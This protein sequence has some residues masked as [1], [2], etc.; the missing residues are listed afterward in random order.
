V[1]ACGEFVIVPRITILVVPRKFRQLN[2]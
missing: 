2:T 1:I